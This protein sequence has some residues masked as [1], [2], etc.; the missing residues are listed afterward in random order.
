MKK[1]VFI[2]LIVISWVLV[3]SV[4]LSYFHGWHLISFK[5]PDNLTITLPLTDKTLGAVHYLG[6]GCSC[7]EHIADY[8]VK[9]KSSDQAKEYVILIGDMKKHIEPLKNAGFQVLEKNVFEV[10]KDNLSSVPFLA[11]YDN[12]QRVQYAGGYTTDAITPFANF[13]D[14]KILKNL[15]KSQKTKSLPIKGCSVSTKFKK[16]LDPMG[17]KYGSVQ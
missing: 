4:I 6:E 1:E 11:F 8:L 3:G 2:P 10:N 17:L 16:L 13:Q 12:Q 15:V 5:S 14:L 7:S 9:R